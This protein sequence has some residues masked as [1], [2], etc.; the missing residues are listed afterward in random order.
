MFPDFGS[1]TDVVKFVHANET[2]PGLAQTLVDALT[3]SLEQ[4]G[5]DHGEASLEVIEGE[6]VKGILQIPS[7]VIKVTIPSGASVCWAVLMSEQR[8]FYEIVKADGSNFP[9][10]S[11]H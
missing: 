10:M 1:L 2:I 3:A 9:H 11:K 4:I 5:Y 6:V 7:M 8:Q